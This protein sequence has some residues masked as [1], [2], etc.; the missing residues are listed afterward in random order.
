MLLITKQACSAYQ[1][2]FDS[3]TNFTIGPSGPEG[4]MGPKGDRGEP[5]FCRVL[6]ADDGRAVEPG[7]GDKTFL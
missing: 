6:G 5:G 4:P 7:L 3:N 1:N 2:L